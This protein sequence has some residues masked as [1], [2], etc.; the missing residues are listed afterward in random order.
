MSNYFDC[1]LNNSMQT[2]LQNNLKDAIEDVGAKVP[3]S[4][5]LWEY[6]EIIRKNLVAN[7]IS[8]VNLKSHDIINIYKTLEDD[9]I[10]YNISTSY[11]TN[12]IPHPNYALDNEEW[13]NKLSVDKIF[14]DLFLN[15]LPNV[16]GVYSGDMTNTNENGDDIKEWN[17]E[18]FNK[19][20]NKIG[21]KPNSNYLRLYLTCQA[22]PIYIYITDSISDLSKGYNIKNSE[23]VTFDIDEDNMTIS[24]HILCIS[25]EQINN[26]E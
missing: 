11:N 25:D 7:T 6:P 3:S 4:A 13:G 10:K 8:N 12:N 20:G 9:E 22:E 23:T 21:L 14:D 1:I 26:I 5:C 17:N 15:I 2:G 18:L 24:A 19:T 16:R